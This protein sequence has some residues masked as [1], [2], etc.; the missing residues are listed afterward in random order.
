MSPAL[1]VT[2]CLATGEATPGA[3]VTM[4]LDE[5][6]ALF[7]ADATPA[8][9]SAAVVEQHLRGRLTDDDLEVEATLTIAVL[10]ARWSRLSL[11]LLG[12]GVSLVESNRPA[13]ATV[14]AHRNEVVFVSNQPGVYGVTLRL[15]ARP[16][17]G[18]GPKV[19]TLRRGPDA[20]DGALHLEAD[21]LHELAGG[22]AS[23]AAVDGAWTARWTGRRPAAAKAEV[24]RPPLEPTI[25]SAHA[26]LV[27]TVEGRARLTLEYA[28]SLDREQPLALRLPEGWALTRAALNGAARPVTP[29]ATLALV[30]TPTRPGERTGKLE[31]VL[32][33]DFGV[34][35]LSGRLPLALPA[36][37]WPTAE[38]EASVHL[39]RVFEYRRLGGSL[40][41][42]ESLTWA[43]PDMPGAALRFRQH[44][45]ASAGPTLELAYAVALEGQYF[46]V[47]GPSRP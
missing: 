1:L 20:R 10:E 22:G 23:L 2:L 37:S 30:A 41:P 12:P 9:F 36:A 17:A 43:A 21:G 24:V 42:A 28:L 6:K 44:L 16:G 33:R 7:A 8:P 19:A 40:E 35:H 47:R 38:V 3:T 5:A 25:A 13:G 15:S 11:F 39:P 34:F 46:R 32:E 4:P 27:S 14:T 45:V 29:G 26:Q 18:A 31:L